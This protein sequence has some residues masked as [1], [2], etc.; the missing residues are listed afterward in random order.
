MPENPPSK[1]RCSNELLAK[2]R[3]VPSLI[4]VNIALSM[5]VEQERQRQDGC[6]GLKAACFSL[7]PSASIFRLME[8]AN[9]SSV[10]MSIG[11]MQVQNELNLFSF[12]FK[13]LH[14]LLTKPYRLFECSV[15]HRHRWTSPGKRQNQRRTCKNQVHRRREPCDSVCFPRVPACCWLTGRGVSTLHRHESAPLKQPDESRGSREG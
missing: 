11:L 3:K 12:A 1:K 9:S 15:Q 14:A 13:E 5:A 6:A 2:R 7:C 4:T 8:L 10:I